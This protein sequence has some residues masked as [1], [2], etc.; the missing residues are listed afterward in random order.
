[1]I[2]GFGKN[3]AQLEKRKLARD[4]RLPSGVRQMVYL[5]LPPGAH[6]ALVEARPD[7]VKWRRR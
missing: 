1:M 5:T 3:Q 6:T 7:V 2:G 4:E